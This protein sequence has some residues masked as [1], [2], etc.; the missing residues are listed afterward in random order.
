MRYFLLVLG[1]SLGLELCL[2]AWMGYR[3]SME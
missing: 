2:L 1:M 3:A